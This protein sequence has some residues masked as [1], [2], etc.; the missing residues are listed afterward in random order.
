MSVIFLD[1]DGVLNSF[2]KHTDRSLPHHEWSPKTMNVF[3][4]EL[5]VY[6]EMVD[7]LN[8]ITD[9]TGARIILSSS[10]RVGYLAE[11]ADVV[12]HLHNA[13]VRGFILGRTPHGPHL[14]TREAEILAWFEENPDEN[15]NSFVILDDD[16]RITYLSDFHVHTEFNVGMQDE[17]VERAIELLNKEVV[18]GRLPS[19]LIITHKKENED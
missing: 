6:P 1:I 4:I 12:I 16:N 11:W 13:G 15:V 17:H 8:K 2:E 9:A 18:I 14:N 7:R 19:S 5:E 10:W 3:G